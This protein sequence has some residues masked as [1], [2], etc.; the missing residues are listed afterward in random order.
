MPIS[1]T[2]SYYRERADEARTQ[3]EASEDEQTK[4]RL[5][6]VASIYDELAERAAANEEKLS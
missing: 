4:R 6:W 1:G 3:A 5:L 2:P